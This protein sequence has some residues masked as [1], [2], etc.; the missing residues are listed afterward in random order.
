MYFSIQ[1][2]EHMKYSSGR[3]EAV[4]AVLLGQAMG[5]ER[6]KIE[7]KAREEEAVKEEEEEEEISL[8]LLE[9][10]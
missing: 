5:W 1:E 2:D 9:P 7:V 4:P 8:R 3:R 10:M 6:K